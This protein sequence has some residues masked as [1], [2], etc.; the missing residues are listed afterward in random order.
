MVLKIF[1]FKVC[2]VFVKLSPFSP[3]HLLIILE[4]MSRMSKAKE[5]GSLAWLVVPRWILCRTIKA[6]FLRPPICVNEHSF[7]CS[8]GLPKNC[9]YLRMLLTL[10]VDL[11]IGS[12]RDTALDFPKQ[13]C[14]D[15]R[16][17]I[18]SLHMIEWSIIICNV[19]ENQIENLRLIL[20]C[21]E[22]LSRIK[23]TYSKCE[24]IGIRVN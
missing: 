4:A 1:L 10:I 8:L 16:W 11:F 23:N 14:Q 3:L 17:L 12:L 24:I 5:S 7:I 19:D 13:I 2:T 15:Y 21:F 6:V 18:Y 9:V 20:C 22:L